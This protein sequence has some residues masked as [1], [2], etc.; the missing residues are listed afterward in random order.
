MNFSAQ[1]MWF[2][3]KWFSFTPGTFSGYDTVFFTVDTVVSGN[4]PRSGS[5]AELTSLELLP[6]KET[7][8]QPFEF[9]DAG[10]QSGYRRDIT[11]QLSIEITG[12]WWIDYYL[13]ATRWSVANVSDS[14]LSRYDL[15]D[16]VNFPLHLYPLTYMTD[17]D[18]YVWGSP[19]E[20]NSPPLFIVHEKRRIDHGPSMSALLRIN[21]GPA[22][23]FTL[24]FSST[25]TFSNLRSLTLQEIPDFDWKLFLR[26]SMKIRD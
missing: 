22:G 16:P 2:A 4:Q 17:K 20:Q 19:T 10:I 26:W 23:I 9:L 7:T 13:H 21:S 5:A 25:K 12:G 3:G 14:L 1:T 15:Y 11:R 18:L 24:A 6:E 8:V